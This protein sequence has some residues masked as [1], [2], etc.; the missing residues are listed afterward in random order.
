MKPRDLV[1]RMRDA[2]FR[3]LTVPHRIQAVTSSS[4]LRR[5]LLEGRPGCVSQLPIL[6]HDRGCHIHDATCTGR[7]TPDTTVRNTC[8]VY[9][10]GRSTERETHTHPKQKNLTVR[11]GEV[12]L[13]PSCPQVV[14]V[15]RPTENE[16]GPSW[17]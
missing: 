8:V 12:W 14:E 6:R 1:A 5:R 3:N 10:A 11:D 16:C 2:V 17:I 7:H 15:H 9:V 13:V 4:E